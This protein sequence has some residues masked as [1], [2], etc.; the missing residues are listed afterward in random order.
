[1]K[2]IK[3]PTNERATERASDVFI[4]VAL[5]DIKKKEKLNVTVCLLE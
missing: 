2:F 1:M 5:I 4:I 3:L